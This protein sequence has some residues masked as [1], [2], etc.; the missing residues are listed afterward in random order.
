MGLARLIT[1]N[2]VPIALETPFSSDTDRSATRGLCVK[3]SV[4]NENLKEFLAA[5][6]LF[7]CL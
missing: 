4:A 6:K 7:S 3:F 5:F 1:M 2:S